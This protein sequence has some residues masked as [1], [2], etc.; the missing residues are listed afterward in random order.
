MA[1]VAVIYHSGYGHT[2]RVAEAV[3]DGAASVD[4]TEATLMTAEEATERMDELEGYDAHIW[5]SPTYMGTVSAPMKAFIDATSKPWMAHKWKDKIAAG[6]TNSSSP[7]GDKVNTL[8]EFAVLAAQHGMIWV[9]QGFLP[10]GY[11]ED[12]GRA[13]PEVNRIGGFLGAM[14][15]SENAEPSP[16]NPPEADVATARQHGARV[17][18]AAQRWGGG[19]L[20]V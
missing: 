7:S 11:Q 16:T 13:H 5:G 19:R 17:A 14:A 18:R 8:V 10:P 15:V 2:K 1:K 20:E 12:D 4:G 6:F 9:G 3:R